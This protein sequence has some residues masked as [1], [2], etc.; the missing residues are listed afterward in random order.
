MTRRHYMKT[1]ILDEEMQGV[2][3]RA[4]AEGLTVAGY[5]RAAIARDADR[6]AIAQLVQF[7]KSAL[8]ERQAT[9]RETATAA[10]D[11]ALVEILQLVRLVAGHLNPQA[12]A[13]ITASVNQ[14]Y[15][16]RV[17]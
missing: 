5:L 4:S 15:P 17:K 1:A 8:Q 7:V 3:A 9:T 12:A 6:V 2:Q 13:R 14:Q 11:S 16:E 10:G